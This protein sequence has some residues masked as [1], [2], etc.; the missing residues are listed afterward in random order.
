MP[1][2]LIFAPCE[3]VIIDQNN[4]ISIISVLQELRVELPE[5]PRDTDGK[6]PVVPMKWDVLSFWT[7]TDDDEPQ[8]VYRARFALIAPTGTELSGFGSA[9]EFSFENKINYRLITT[10]LGF[11]VLHEGRHVVRLWLTKKGDAE[12]DPVSEFPIVLNRTKPKD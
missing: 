5:L 12:G 11:P 7:R 4:V 8:T 2:L 10:V 6:T 1:R 9:G 3:K